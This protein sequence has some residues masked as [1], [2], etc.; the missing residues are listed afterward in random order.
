MGDT[1]A[2]L[3]SIYLFFRPVSYRYAAW[4][5][6]R[7]RPATISL[8]E[9]AGIIRGFEM[10]KIERY[11]VTA[12]ATRLDAIYTYIKYRKSQDLEW[13]TIR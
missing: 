5:K 1:V 3:S 4:Y 6:R 9:I 11:S 2:L 10:N 12:K 13:K 8:K 7:K